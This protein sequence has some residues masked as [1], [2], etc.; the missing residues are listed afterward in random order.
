[1]K[2]IFCLETEWEL[3][4]SKKMRDKASMLPLLHFLE[5]SNG[6]EFVFRN[7]ASR[8]DLR[9]YINELEYKTYKDFQIIYLAFHGA[10][11]SLEIPADKDNPITF[12]ELAEIS[13]GVFQDKIIHF[14]SCRTLLTSDERIL[15]FKEQTGARLVSGYTKK[16]DFIRSSILD[17]AYFSE[18]I[19]IQNVGAIEKRM[20]KRYD[21][22]MNDLGFKII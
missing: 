10:S 1:M 13:N 15:E 17:I 5:Q 20:K 2:K 14:G 12:S 11:K 16:I 9:Y 6:V 8:V 21:Q 7:V 3:S 19:D 4:K 18:L 22:L